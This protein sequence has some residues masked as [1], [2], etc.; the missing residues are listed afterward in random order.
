[1]ISAATTLTPSTPA[2]LTIEPAGI[3]LARRGYPW[4]GWSMYLAISWTWCI[5]M[6]LPVLLIRDFG[7]GGYLAFLLPNC[8]GSALMGRVLTA[9]SSRSISVQHASMIRL[10]SIV[11]AGF[12]AFFIGWIA[13]AA[14]FGAIPGGLLALAIAVPAALLPVFRSISTTVA[15]W[16][17]VLA[18]TASLLLIGGSL[19][20]EG[21]PQL[22]QIAKA[23]PMTD[24]L[25][26]LAPVCVFGFAL[27]PYLDGTFHTALRGSAPKQG[28]TFGLGFMVL[29]A[30]MVLLTPLYT[31]WVSD[32]NFGRMLIIWPIAVHL[33]MQTSLTI[34]L[35]AKA[36]TDDAAAAAARSPA[37]A[38][39]AHSN[40]QKYLLAGVV[41]ASA[42]L[43]VASPEV[44]NY[45]GLSGPELLFRGFLVFYGLVFPA[46]V[47][48]CIVPFRQRRVAH[49]RGV[50]IWIVAVLL[51]LPC[52]WMGFIERQMWWL[53]I[54]MGVL[55]LAKCVPAGAK[56]P[57]LVTPVQ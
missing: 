8:I 21:Q 52:F 54:A 7:W 37:A 13:S 3:D 31:G 39:P 17:C 18:F 38:H 1:M 40:S 15:L 46:Y 19:L 12:Q 25:L 16:L 26:W 53:A 32:A 55:A 20:I 4:P 45:A 10:F 51:A 41:T 28:R 47:W 22:W 30:V 9:E 6:F 48:I 29:F 42:I 27:C 43:G 36:G 49:G 23:A 34:F 35:H 50:I 24:Q 33:L 11:T 5:G 44:P 2:N 56:S 57:R 14:G